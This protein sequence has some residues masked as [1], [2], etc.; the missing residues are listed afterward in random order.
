MSNEIRVFRFSSGVHDDYLTAMRRG[1]REDNREKGMV[2][3]S[4]KIAKDLHEKNISMR[5]AIFVMKKAGENSEPKMSEC[6]VYQ[7]WEK[8]VLKEKEERDEGRG[9][10]LDL[11]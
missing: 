4:K 5:N 3:L 10:F 6:E 8:V 2:R 1:F 11:I 9:F 7:F